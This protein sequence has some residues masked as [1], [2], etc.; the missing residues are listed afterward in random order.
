MNKLK[1]TIQFDNQFST[2]GDDYLPGEP[3]S[4]TE[5][6]HYMD[7]YN[8]NDDQA[9]TLYERDQAGFDFD[10]YTNGLGAIADSFIKDQAD[11]L[12]A[13]SKYGI[14][15]SSAEFY[16]PHA[17]NYE[18]DSVDINLVVDTDMLQ[19]KLSSIKK[20]LDAYFKD[21]K[22]KSYDGYMSQEKNKTD[23]LD[24]QEGRDYY[25]ILHAIF[26]HENIDI[27]DIKQ[28]LLDELHNE[29]TTAYH[30]AMAIDIN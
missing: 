12:K 28:D 19:K 24:L 20:E 2:Y 4:I 17:Y 27:D 29:C 8:L 25:A 21:V 3:E 13:L 14:K 7:E 23:E 9:T 22:Q 11:M 1:T 6:E 5:V 30:E 18:G 16:T 26:E 15:I 10:E